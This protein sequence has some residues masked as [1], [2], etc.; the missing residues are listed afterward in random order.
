MNE[1]SVDKNPLVRDG[2][3]QQGRYPEALDPTY[4]KVDERSEEDLRTFAEEFAALIQYYNTLNKREGNWVPFFKRDTEDTD[5]PHYALYLTFLRLLGKLQ[6]QVNTLTDAHLKFFYEQVLGLQ[7]QPPQPDSVH[8]I[9]EP[10]KRVTGHQVLAGSKLKAAEKDA[11]KKDV[12]FEVDQTLTVRQARVD[13]LRTVYRQ[14]ENAQLHASVIANSVDGLGGKLD[15]ENPAW[16]TFGNDVNPQDDTLPNAAIGFALAS[17]TL[18]MQEGHRKLIITLYFG[19]EPDAKLASE[20]N[21][22]LTLTGEQ[23]WQDPIVPKLTHSA[24]DKTLSLEVELSTED[25]PVLPYSEVDY[26]EG[27]NTQWPMVKIMLAEGKEA[28]YPHLADLKLSKITLKQAVSDIRSL[29]LHNDDSAL[30]PSKPFRPFGVLPKLGSAFYIGYPEAFYKKL[31]TFQLEMEYHG[32]PAPDMGAYYYGYFEADAIKNLQ[33]TLT[34]LQNDLDNPPALKKVDES[35]PTPTKDEGNNAGAKQESSAAEDVVFGE[36][37][38]D[39]TFNYTK[40]Y[41]DQINDLQNTLTSLLKI[42][43]DTS[44]LQKEIRAAIDR[45]EASRAAM[46]LPK[47]SLVYQPIVKATNELL[48]ELG[49]AEDLDNNLWQVD[50]SYQIGRAWK[51]LLKEVDNERGENWFNPIAP[52]TPQGAQ[53]VRK[54]TYG[55]V[56]ALADPSLLGEEYDRKVATSLPTDLGLDTSRGFVKFTLTEPNVPFQAFGHKEYPSLYTKRIIDQTVNKDSKAILP[57][58]PYTPLVKSIVLQYTV[59]QEISLID[60]AKNVAEE[61]YH[62]GPFGHALMYSPNYQCEEGNTAPYAFPHFANR[63]NL[64]IGLTDAKP[65]ETYA[66]LFQMAEG[67]GST[68]FP[69]DTGFGWYYLTAQNAWKSLDSYIQVDNTDQFLNSG[70]VQMVMPDDLANE[71]TLMRDTRSW[72]RVSVPNTPEAENQMVAIHTNAVK[73]TFKDQ[74]NDL[75]RLA[76]ALPADSLAKLVN[77]DAQIKKVYQ[78]YASFGGKIKEENA[79]YYTRTSERLRHKH[80]AINIWDFERLV[81]QHFPSVYKVKCLNHTSPTSERAPGHVT[82]VIVSNLRNQNGVDLLKPSTSTSKLTAIKDLCLGLGNP[83]LNRPGGAEKL[84][85]TDP[86]YEQIKV[87]FKVH[88]HPIPGLDANAERKN[89][90]DAI[91]RYLSPWAYTEGVDILFEGRVHKSQILHFVENYRGLAGTEELVDFVTCFKMYHT[92]EDG[93]GKLEEKEADVITPTR[94]SAILVSHKEHIITLVGDTENCACDDDPQQ[95]TPTEELEGIDYW[96]VGSDFSVTP[97]TS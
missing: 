29:I 31:D 60:R 95:T 18:L 94:S 75:N 91:K 79:S 77:K 58:E 87:E 41:N 27:Y 13:L 63:G 17:P 64:Y 69:K 28:L 67:T 93:D 38:D 32:V 19:T 3:S 49:T 33:K 45:L 43:L 9:F 23:A 37:I 62:V 44:E 78:P 70:I 24:T 8:L 81:L 82:L 89:L 96:T 30:D 35:E 74:G 59:V 54:F 25:S 97:G 11:L 85:V 56:D 80:R 86:T 76:E 50:P 88:F 90:N 72:L 10:G 55:R 5:D 42:S 71:N 22:T 6:E 21:F 53:D 47:F 61:F 14:P 52:S 20:G 68:K 39:D 40:F 84:H 92:V 12:F 1:E 73:A 66:L 83:F 26:Q 51:P 36:Y 4:V 46:I 16:Y 7:P 15:K 34:Q 57:R 48:T 65:G 2:T